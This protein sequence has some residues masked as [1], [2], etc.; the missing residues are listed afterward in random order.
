MSSYV[1][2]EVMIGTLMTVTLK[3]LTG[4]RDLSPISVFPKSLLSKVPIFNLKLPFQS[5]S[6][7]MNFSLCLPL[8]HFASEFFH[9]S[10]D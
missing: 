9:I 7:K 4:Q 10:V 8:S 5:K 6:Q 1:M 3:F 2:V